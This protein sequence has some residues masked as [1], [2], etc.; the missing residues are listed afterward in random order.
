MWYKAKAIVRNLKPSEWKLFLTFFFVSLASL[1][2]LGFILFNKFT[3]PVPLKGGL[4]TEG[5]V[6]QPVFV[7][8]I[9]SGNNDADRDLISLIFCNAFEVAEKIEPT[10]NNQSW[11]IRLKDNLFWHDGE[12][13]TSDDIIFTLNKIQDPEFHSPLSATWQGI[14]MNRV[15][16]LEISI[17]LSSPYAFFE[18]NLKKLYII[19]KHIYADIPLNN[20]RLSDYNLQPVGC[21]AYKFD[22]YKKKS[23]GFIT[24]YSLVANDKYFKSSPFVENLDINFY[25]SLKK[26]SEDFN[27]AKIDGLGGLTKS[28]Y[29]FISRSNNIYKMATP[30]YYAVFMN[31]SVNP[32]LQD[33][34]VRLALDA[35]VNKKDLIEKIFGGWADPIFGPITPNFIGR[36]ISEVSNNEAL[37]AKEILENSGWKLIENEVR[38]KKIKN[39]TV[40]LEFNLVVPEVDF[41]VNTANYLE[42]AWREIGVKTNIIIISPEEINN[43]AIKNRNYELLIFGNIL[44]GSPDIFSFWHSSEKLH[45]GLNLSLFENKTVDKLI[46]EIRKTSDEEER[47]GDLS[48]LQSLIGKDVPA[49]FLY[50]PYYVYITSKNLN[51]FGTK[52]I[53]TP[54]SRFDDINNWFVKTARELK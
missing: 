18:E 13:L 35:A 47:I 48:A 27:F 32:A 22:S 10:N 9:I 43:D 11:Q 46:E 8:P 6:G 4:F 28:E 38:E 37:E 41:L 20:W 19:P 33:K 54:P 7:N 3:V 25:T 31:Q 52:L 16:E 30:R 14:V 42:K 45:P 34:N 53:I 51:G 39:K 17:K 29:D 50:S 5:I 21:G 44:G 12:K 24:K 23:D 36:N 2:F 49:V 15:S 26:A 1:I 40:S